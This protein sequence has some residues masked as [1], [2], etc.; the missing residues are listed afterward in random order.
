VREIIIETELALRPILRRNK[1]TSKSEE[2]TLRNL[3]TI[4]DC[5]PIII[6]NHHSYDWK[7]MSIMNTEG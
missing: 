1:Y 4:S 2:Y 5:F 6:N 7:I 3:D